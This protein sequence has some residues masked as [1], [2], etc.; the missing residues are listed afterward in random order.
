MIIELLTPLLLA[1]EPAQIDVP[2]ISYSHATQAAD[3]ASPVPWGTTYNATRTFDSRGQ[4][5][6]NDADND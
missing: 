4:P 5:F 2:A 3:N 1:H 6:D